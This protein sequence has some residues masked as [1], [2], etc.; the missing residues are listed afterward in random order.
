LLAAAAL[1]AQFHQGH[2]AVAAED[3]LFQATH[4]LQRDHLYK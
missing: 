3:K 2:L 4:R 1:G